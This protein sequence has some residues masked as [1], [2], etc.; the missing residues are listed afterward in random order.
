MKH[1]VC[2][3]GGHSSALVAIEVT[4]KFGK[5]NTIIVNHQCKLED[6]DVERFENEIA[7]YLNM[8]ITYASFD[9]WE[10]KDQFDVVI[11]Q[12]RDDCGARRASRSTYRP[13]RQW[14]SVQGV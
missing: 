4:R 13:Q 1:I 9:G 5:E 12:S 8:P 7:I 11:E 14:C 6:E 3:S 2:Y 10:N